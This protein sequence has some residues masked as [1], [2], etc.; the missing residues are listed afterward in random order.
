MSKCSSTNSPHP[1]LPCR[2]CGIGGR[3]P[4]LSLLLNAYLVQERWRGRLL[5]Q[6]PQWCGGGSGDA[7]LARATGIAGAAAAPFGM[8]HRRIAGGWGSG[9]ILPVEQPLEVS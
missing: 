2:Q 3:V 6:M 4:L 7:G 8:S 5:V 9:F 1:I